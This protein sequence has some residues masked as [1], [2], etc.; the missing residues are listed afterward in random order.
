MYLCVQYL[1]ENVFIVV[2]DVS[3]LFNATVLTQKKTGGE[4]GEVERQMLLW[5]GSPVS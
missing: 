4:R 2:S 3:I 5:W 1:K